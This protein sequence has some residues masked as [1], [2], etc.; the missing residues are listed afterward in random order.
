MEE[1]Q[2]PQL[3]TSFMIT[4]KTILAKEA[5][6]LSADDKAFLRARW[7]YVG[8]EDRN[9][10]KDVVFGKSKK[11]ESKGN[12]QSTT[13]LDPNAEQKNNTTPPDDQADTEPENPFEDEE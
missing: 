6:E 10:L 13:P 7:H 5:R 8:R 2:K 11:D 9:R 4:L 12:S 3:D 1:G